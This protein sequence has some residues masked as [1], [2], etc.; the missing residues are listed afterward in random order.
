MRPEWAARNIVI[1]CGEIWIFENMN[2]A[3]VT[4]RDVLWSWKFQNKNS[5]AQQT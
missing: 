2:I 3:T 4:V 5:R 1:V